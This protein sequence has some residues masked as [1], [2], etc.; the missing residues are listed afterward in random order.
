MTVAQVVEIFSG[1]QGEGPLVGSR[2]VFVR[3][4]GCNLDCDYCDTPGAHGWR[5]PAEIERAAGSME[6]RQEPNPM[7]PAKV[8]EEVLRLAR[9]VPILSVT[10]TGG[11]PLQS[12]GFLA[13]AIPRLREAGWRQFLETNGTLPDELVEVIDLFDYLSVDIK[14]PSLSRGVR[15]MSQ[16]ERFVEIV[17]ESKKAG[18]LKLVLAASTTREEIKR[19]AV[20]ARD[21]GLPL[22]LQPVA[23]VEGGPQPPPAARVLSAQA[24]A[25][26]IHADVRVIRQMQN[27]LGLR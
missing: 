22:I 1:V 4:A 10:W 11:E 14:F 18:C 27:E 24:E 5:E 25:L 23:V 3:L 26:A 6:F 9:E 13:E 8:A 20:L 15:G 2:Q 7:T 21:T 16:C 17:R 12:A 19:A